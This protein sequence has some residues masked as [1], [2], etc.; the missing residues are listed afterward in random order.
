[1]FLCIFCLNC[2][3]QVPQFSTNLF[4]TLARRSSRQGA[5]SCQ[6]CKD[7]CPPALA[8]SDSGKTSTWSAGENPDNLG[9]SILSPVAIE[10]PQTAPIVTT[11]RDGAMGARVWNVVEKS[12]PPEPTVFPSLTSVP[13]PVASNPIGIVRLH[14]LI[15]VVEVC[16]SW[17]MNGIGQWGLCLF[18]VVFPVLGL[19]HELSCTMM[20]LLTQG[21]E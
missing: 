7:S 6:G 13:R 5:I 3:M 16:P 18:C 4:N 21:L 9:L 15:R 2:P 8:G 10:T 11:R 20:L 17:H 19:C 14:I 12:I 1:M